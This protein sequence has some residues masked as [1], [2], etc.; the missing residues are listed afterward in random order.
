MLA[1]LRLTTIVL[2]MNKA[3]RDSYGGT[4]TCTGT[5][6]LPLKCSLLTVELTITNYFDKSVVLFL[7][8]AAAAFN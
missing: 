5:L 8:G 7:A 3:A 6:T 1:S 4:G 2:C